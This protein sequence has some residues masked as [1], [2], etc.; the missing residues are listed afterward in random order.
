MLSEK[1]VNETPGPTPSK[2]GN[3]GILNVTSRRSDDGTLT[4][5]LEGELDVYSAGDLHNKLRRA[6]T[7]STDLVIDLT[8]LEFIDCAGL[9]QLVEAGRR[10]RSRGGR[11]TLVRGPLK[12]HRLFVLTGLE[13]EFQ[14]VPHA[15]GD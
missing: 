12:V 5:G 11:L 1:A 14:F 7:G 4:V 2:T 3:F 10:A 13:R 15:V 8:R 6:E 9:H